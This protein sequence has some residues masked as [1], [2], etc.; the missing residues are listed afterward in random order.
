MQAMDPRH[1]YNKYILT[2][3]LEI[4]LWKNNTPQGAGRKRRNPEKELLI[5]VM[6]EKK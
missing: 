4:F 2:R 5:M 6:D 3:F 1:T